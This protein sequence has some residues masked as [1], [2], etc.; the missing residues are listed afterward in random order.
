MA[1]AA[2]SGYQVTALDAFSDADTQRMAHAS[3]SVEYA[4]GQF[5]A[6]DFER[7]LNR[8]DV[9]D[10]TGLVY[11]SGFEAAPALL[12][13]AARH[14]RLIGNTP[15]VLA[16][17]KH[18]RKFFMLLDELK[19]PHPEV[20]FQSP[21]KVRGWVY[22]QGG[23]SG[24]THVRKALPS[25]GI[26]P[27]AG[28]YFQ[29]IVPGVPVSLLFAA[30]GSQAKAIG[31]NLQWLSATPAMP[32]RYGGAVS[33]ARLPDTIKQRLLQAAQ[34]LTGAV[35]LRGL[36]SIDA[37]MDGDQLWVLEVN[38]RFS[39]TF[40]LYQSATC[41]LCELH[42]RACDGNI[43]DWPQITRQAKAHQ[44]I[45]ASHD[46]TAPGTTA[47]PEWV[48]DMP[49]PASNVAVGSPL[50]TVLATADNVDVAQALVS[51]RAKEIEA[52]IENYRIDF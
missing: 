40:D 21:G 25:G 26:A 7:V 8:L 6:A 24:G 27:E 3:Y 4:N 30:D 20:G 14:L 2:A 5:D 34:Q 36:N 15:R 17:L 10:V 11:G 41:N 35:G 49:V 28:C 33:H 46:V 29:R 42:L 50:C 51:G 44:I 38:P 37:M 19:I 45:Y 23:G 39:A 32:Y 18:P 9:G 47:W 52:M 13:R 12:D 48:A 31:F 43:T 22:K 16:S 1:A